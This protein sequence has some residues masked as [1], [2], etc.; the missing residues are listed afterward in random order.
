MVDWIQ[1]L[2]PWITSH[3]PFEITNGEIPVRK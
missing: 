1:I 2:N 3:V